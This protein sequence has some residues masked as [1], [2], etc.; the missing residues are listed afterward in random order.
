MFGGT[1]FLGLGGTGFGDFVTNA[2]GTIESAVQKG[3]TFISRVP[4]ILTEAGQYAGDV[5]YNQDGKVQ[6]EFIEQGRQFESGR[7]GANVGQFFNENF[8]M[9]ALF[10]GLIALVMILKK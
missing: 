5:I 10:G 2:A 1:G 8:E 4:N 9:I 3:A 7:T 6:S